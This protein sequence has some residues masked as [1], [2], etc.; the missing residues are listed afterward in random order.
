M[1]LLSSKINTKNMVPMCRQLATTYDAGIP[2]LRGL[3]LVKE[4]TQDR[5]AREVLQ[6]IADQVKNGETLGGAARKHEKRLPAYFIELLSA[7]ERSGQL[8]VMLRDLAAYYEDQLAMRRSIIGAMVYPIFQLSA[9]W[10]LGT[11]ALRLISQLDFTGKTAFSFEAYLRDYFTFQA[12]AMLVFAIIVGVAIVLSRL[13]IFQWIWGWF[14]TFMWPIK[15]VTRKF[16]LAR[17]FRSLSLLIGS[18]MHIRACIENSA[19]VTVNPYIQRDLLKAV[20]FVSDGAT[21]VQAFSGSR[22]LTPMAR[23]MLLVGEQSGNLEQ[24]LMKVSSYHLEEANHAVKVAMRVSNV[25][26]LL[27]IASL[28]GYIYIKFFTTYYGN[29]MNIG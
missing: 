29:L 15:N 7:G 5:S 11:F 19:A 22:T 6:S 9:A 18:G 17:F 20:P 28:V 24:A 27:A 12:K 3:A 1:G 21:L 4:S 26:L 2:I 16:A 13:G 23:Q 10:F 8:A 25:F 14:A